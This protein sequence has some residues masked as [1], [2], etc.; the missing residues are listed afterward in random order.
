[1]S[2]SI[3]LDTSKCQAYGLCMG[4]APDHFDV[5]DGRSIAV[6]LRDAAED[7]EREDLEEAVRSCPAQA[8]TLIAIG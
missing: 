1:M 3:T 4:I 7:D 8:I 5:P 2:I 6:L